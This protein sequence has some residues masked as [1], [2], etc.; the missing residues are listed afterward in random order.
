MG[1]K[2]AKF[3]GENIIVTERNRRS[4]LKLGATAGTGLA[5]GGM[6]LSAN[7]QTQNE[8]L[9][10][11]TGNQSKVEDK[12]VVIWSSGDREVALKLVFMYTYRAK[13]KKRWGDIKLL[14]WGPSA[15]LL[16]VDV[17]LQE[18]VKRMKDAE[19]EI[20]ACKACAD[21]YKVSKKLTDLGVDV[22]YMGQELTDLMKSGWNT[23][24]F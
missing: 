9:P 8:D 18:Y 16:A 12:L 21:M 11:N 19:L 13:R 23:L 24:T 17:E 7:A 2:E 3:S 4:F 22:K 10:L 5:L 6:S 20:L 1:E 14:I 15:K